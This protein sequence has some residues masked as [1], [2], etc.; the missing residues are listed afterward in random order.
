MSL[1]VFHLVFITLSILLA[2]AFGVWSLNE[3]STSGGM[4]FLLIAVVSFGGAVALILYERLFLRKFR[5]V[6]NL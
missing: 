4:M 6:S 5:N 1:K 3:Y 2:L